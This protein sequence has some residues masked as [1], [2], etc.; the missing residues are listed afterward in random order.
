MKRTLCA[1]LVLVMCLALAMPAFAAEDDFVP[2]ISYKDAPEVDAA[3][4]GNESVSSCIVV[5]SILAAQNGTT[6]IAEEDCNLL[7][8]VYAKLLDGS[9]TLPLEGNY[10]IRDLI[11]LSF[12]YVGCVE[13]GHTHEATLNAANTFVKVTFDM[14]VEDT[15][16]IVVLHYYDNEWHEI[17]VTHNGDGTITCEFDHFS[18]VAFVNVEGG[19]E[20]PKNGDPM[21]MGLWIGL[22]VASAAALV[23][24]V[25]N[26]RR[27]FG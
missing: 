16:D 23:V 2:S 26:R 7:L 21:V 22:M 17:N 8:S 27:I 13:A 12:E 6:D 3:V 14:G 25:A 18:P 24:G 1:I 10:V 20:P 11:D 5:T 9:M 4:M 15:S 19:K